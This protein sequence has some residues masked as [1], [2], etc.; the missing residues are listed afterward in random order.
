VKIVKTCPDKL[1]IAAYYDG[2]LAADRA[3]VV[4]A[5][6]VECQACRAELDALG[7]I[8]GSI[9]SVKASLSQI[10]AYRLHRRIQE[11]M[12]QNLLGLARRVCAAAAMVLLASSIWLVSQPGRE[13]PAAPPWTDA[14]M[15]TLSISSDVHS[16][17]GAWYLGDVRAGEPDARLPDVKNVND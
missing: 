7:L 3:Q 1:E 11:A 10:S 5:H 9:S 13:S 16:P 14:S 12:D 4:R 6:L 8:S 15:A 17:A 2:E